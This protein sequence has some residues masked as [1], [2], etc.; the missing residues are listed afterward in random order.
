M[1][2]V[3]CIE[4]WTFFRPSFSTIQ[5]KCWKMRTRK[6]SEIWCTSRTVKSMFPN[7]IAV[8]ILAN[9]YLLKVNNINFRK[10]CEI[11]SKLA[12]QTSERRHWR[13]S[14]VFSVNFEYIS[15]LFLLFLLLTLNKWI[16]VR[17]RLLPLFYDN[18]E[19][20]KN[21]Q[22]RWLTWVNLCYFFITLCVLHITTPGLVCNEYWT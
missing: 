22:F 20:Y 5:C 11:C 18:E 1:K 15:H 21:L 14:D 2:Y 19:L 13:H 12:I 17:I 8:A 10:R 4:F 16:L 9:I 6:N 3:T 7:I